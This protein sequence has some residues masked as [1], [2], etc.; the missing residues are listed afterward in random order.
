MKKKKRVLTKEHRDKI[1]KAHL[2]SNHRRGKT[3]EELYGIDKANQLKV[4]HSK[5]LLGKKRKPFS[6]EWKHNMSESRKHSLVFK[7]FMQSKEYRELRSKIAVETQLGINYEDWKNSKD[8]RYWYYKRVWQ[9]T[10]SQPLEL[11]ENYNKRGSC[12]NNGYHLDHKIP[13]SYG[14]KNNIPEEVIGNIENLAFIPWLDN[15]KKGAKYE[16]T[17]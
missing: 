3:Y 10:N 15:I 13:I 2:L 7:E 1:S 4:K 11:L 12:T 16:E 9:I 8:D 17:K 6:K 5:D 14:F